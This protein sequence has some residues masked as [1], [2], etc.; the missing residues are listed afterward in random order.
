MHWQKLTVGV[1]PKSVG[2]PTKLMET[3][4]LIGETNRHN[5]QRTISI[6]KSG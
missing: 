3:V 6:A 4:R 1:A 2:E 5:Y